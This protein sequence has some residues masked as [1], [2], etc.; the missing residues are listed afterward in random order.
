MGLLGARR[1]VRK[2]LREE[3]G[4]FCIAI[5]KKCCPGLTSDVNLLSPAIKAARR[6]S[7]ATVRTRTARFCYFLRKWQDHSRNYDKKY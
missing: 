7:T 3:K 2:G 5:E 6:W 1:F 4:F